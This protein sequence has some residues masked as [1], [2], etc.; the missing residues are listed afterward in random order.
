MQQVEDEVVD[1]IEY[2]GDEKE[3][4]DDW[5]VAGTIVMSRG[6]F[7][8]LLLNSFIMILFIGL[9]VR[10]HLSVYGYQS[11]TLVDLVLLPSDTCVSE[12]VENFAQHKHDLYT[13]IRCKIASNVDYKLATDMH[14]GLRG[15]T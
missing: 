12:P 1:P 5:V 8:Y 15:L 10:A 13:E 14:W 4:E 6:V 2:S 3:F 9:Q 11:C 7:Y